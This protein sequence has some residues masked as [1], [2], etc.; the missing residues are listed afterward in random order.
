MDENEKK[1]QIEEAYKELETLW[2]DEYI[3][4]DFY[5]ELDDDIIISYDSFDDDCERN[6]LLDRLKFFEKYNMYPPKG[7]D[8]YLAPIQDFRAIVE[9]FENAA[10]NAYEEWEEKK[11]EEASKRAD[12][13][14]KEQ[15]SKERLWDMS[16]D[17]LSLREDMW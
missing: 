8:P 1:R 14:L 11:M 4:S 2:E 7:F 5:E 9:E 15:R 6:C 13:A 10:A 16:G 3:N 12:I 17:D